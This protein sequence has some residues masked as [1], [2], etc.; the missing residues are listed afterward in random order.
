MKS[1]IMKELRMGIRTSKF[2]VI[3][4]SFLFF[5]ILTPIMMKF[6]LPQL[7]LNQFQGMEEATISQML[8]M[9]QKGS[10]LGYMSDLFEI[11]TIV[12][13][14]ALS[15]LLAQEIKENTLVLPICSGKKLFSIVTSKLVVFSI[16]LILA[17]T[18]GMV[19]CYLYAGVLFAFDIELWSVVVIGLLYG[20]YMIFLL[21]LVM[22]F[23]TIIKS[24]IG[25]GFMT[26]GFS[27]FLYFIGSYL[28]VHMYL[29]SGLLI[30][31]QNIL[32]NQSYQNLGVT[33]A[34][35]IILVLM[36][37]KITHMRLEHREW[38]ER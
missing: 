10:L 33:L 15:G 17:S 3:T 6:I 16:F 21:N 13:V 4:A 38:N 8:D 24:S 19:I 22:L 30:S 1:D 14:F 34:I 5:A 32:A 27:L 2:L 18:L 25:T 35:S 29:P 23:G 28:D 7:L 37:S 11:G 26:L 9:S 20:G 36:I 12:V 31:A